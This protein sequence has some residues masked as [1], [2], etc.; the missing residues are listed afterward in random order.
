MKKTHAIF[1]LDRS[2]SME[3]C[4][5][6]TI[7][8]FNEQ[9]NA[10]ASGDGKVF[11]SCVQFDNPQDIET[12]Y[13]R[14]KVAAAPR[15]TIDTF[16]PRG[17][18]AMLDA[19]GKAITIADGD[20]RSDSLLIVVVSDGG[21]NA[22]RTE[23]YDSIAEKIKVRTAKGNW[24]FAYIGANQDLSDISKRMNIPLG[25]TMAYHS[26]PLGT[27]TAYTASAGS[28]LTFAAS[29]SLGSTNLFNNTAS[30]EP[31]KNDINAKI[32]RRAKA[33]E[34]AGTTA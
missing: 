25:N 17:M 3:S 33:K 24:T 19:V 4:R 22:S 7:D 13:E 20:K 12:L 14:V 9:L 31:D 26:T 16:V 29:A 6:A 1:V 15:L 11:V 34:T 10:L 23:S 28:T 5:K 2:G 32:N 30:P 8:G 18:T 27:R 21:E